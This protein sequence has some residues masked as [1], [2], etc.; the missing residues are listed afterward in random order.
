MKVHVEGGYCPACGQSFR[1]LAIHLARYAEKDDLHLILY[2]T[3]TKLTTNGKKL[4]EMRDRV[5]ELLE[6]S[7]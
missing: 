2:A 5:I 6:R 7:E 3:V 4:R 1:N